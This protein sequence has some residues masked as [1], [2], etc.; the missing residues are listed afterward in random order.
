MRRVQRRP[1]RDREIVIDRT[2]ARCGGEYEWSVHVQRFA[3]RAGL[4]T[5]Q[6]GS[7]THGTSADTCWTTERDRMLIDAADARHAHHDLDDAL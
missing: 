7:L 3:P 5:A 4:T 1:N 6:I 2:R